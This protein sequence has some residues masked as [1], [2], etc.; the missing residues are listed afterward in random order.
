MSFFIIALEE[1]EEA[2]AGR[3]LEIAHGIGTAF[4]GAK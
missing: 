4:N 3:I 2:R 1:A